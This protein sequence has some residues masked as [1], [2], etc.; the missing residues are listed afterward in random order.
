M[1]NPSNSNMLDLGAV[2]ENI[3]YEIRPRWRRRS[4]SRAPSGGGMLDK[5]FLRSFLAA[6]LSAV[7]LALSIRY[8]FPECEAARRRADRA[9]SS[10]SPSGGE[11]VMS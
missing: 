11:D 8:H 10:D 3:R 6:V 7:D 2:I 4:R 9:C 5:A 1:T